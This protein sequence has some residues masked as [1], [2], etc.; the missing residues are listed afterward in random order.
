MWRTRGA[1]LCLALSCVAAQEGEW[2]SVHFYDVLP[3][4]C[5]DCDDE[6]F[7]LKDYGNA[8]GDA[9]FAIRSLLP[10][11]L[12][13][14]C[15]AEQGD[16]NSFCARFN[17]IAVGTCYSEAGYEG[18]QVARM[19]SVEVPEGEPF[20]E[21]GACNPGEGD[22]EICDY[23]CV[24][25]S[26]YAPPPAAGIGVQRLTTGEICPPHIGRNISAE[27]DQESPS[28]RALHYDY[29]LCR[30][31]DGLWYSVGN[32]SYAGEHWRNPTL[33]KAID[34]DC[35]MRV[36]HETVQT[37][38]GTACF[39]SCE[40]TAVGGPYNQTSDCYIRCFYNTLLGPGGDASG[41][42]PGQ[43]MSAQEITDAWLRGFEACPE[44]E[45]EAGSGVSARSVRRHFTRNGRS[46]ALLPSWMKA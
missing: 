18:T 32:A 40:G 34:A 2:R 28:V 38:R 6:T 35:Q 16:R 24:P 27:P 29:N 7:A 37:A 1:A 26:R 12:C 33:V 30:E 22:D 20:G 8:E 4:P 46:A 19:I 11:L 42:E 36:L 17:G 13:P 25:N 31:L 39:D 23:E 3:A 41:F 44:F 43:G 10:P 21:Y 9:Y 14:R 45:E 5:R 15:R